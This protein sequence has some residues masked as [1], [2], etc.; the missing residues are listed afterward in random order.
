MLLYAADGAILLL[1]QDYL[2]AAFHAWVLFNLFQ[3][4]KALKQLK[5][6]EAMSPLPV[7]ATPIA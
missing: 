3:G 1:L 7:T 4:V 5:A 6:L 2:S